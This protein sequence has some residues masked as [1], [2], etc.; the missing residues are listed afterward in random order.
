MIDLT[1]LG[2]VTGAS[3]LVSPIITRYLKMF[4]R[5]KKY[6]ALLS[7]LVGFV[8]TTG[9]GLIAGMDIGSALQLGLAGLA[10]GG[11]GSSGRD[12]IKLGKK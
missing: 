8:A 6:R 2:G 3:A 1:L 7:P 9:I 12:F 4:V 10:G 11:I 5:K